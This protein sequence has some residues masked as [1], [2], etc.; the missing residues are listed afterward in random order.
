MKISELEKELA[1]LREQVG[2]VEVEC[3][4][5]AGD[6]ESVTTV[7]LTLSNTQPP[8]DA[9]SITYPRRVVLIDS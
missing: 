3:R 1:Q 6:F 8:C 4:N 9:I 5:A 7:A 2:D